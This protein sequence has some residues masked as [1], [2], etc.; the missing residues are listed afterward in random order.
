MSDPIVTLRCENCGKPCRAMLRGHDAP[1]GSDCC[2][3]YLLRRITDDE[4]GDIIAALYAE[5][6]EQA[7]AE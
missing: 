1:L 2:E 7:D 5:R 4:E 6:E 3:G